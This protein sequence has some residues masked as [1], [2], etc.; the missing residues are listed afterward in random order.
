MKR[1][2]RL[3]DALDAFAAGKPITHA[4]GLSF[5]YDGDV[6][7]ERVWRPLI[8]RF[9]VRRPLVVCGGS[10]ASDDYGP[11]R[12]GTPLGVTVLRTSRPGG[13]IFHPKLFIAVR[14]GAVMV[15]VGS[16]N[17]TSGGLSGNLELLSTLT[18]DPEQPDAAPRGLL[19]SIR[20]FV[21]AHVR[22]SLVDRVSEASLEALDET[23][24]FVELVEQDLPERSRRAPYLSFLHTYD[25]A[26]WPRLLDHHGEDRL[27][28]VVVLSPFYE[29]EDPEA[30]SP[31]GLIAEVLSAQT[32]WAARAPMPRL[33]LHVGS[34]QAA[35]AVGG[36]PH[37]SLAREDGAV[38]LLVQN[39]S[40]E[41]RRLHAKM[42]A[43]FGK[44][45]TTVLWG[46]PNFTPSAF[47]RGAREGE[48]GNV[49]C[50]LVLRVPARDLTP[51]ALVDQ[52]DL[53]PL[54]HVHEGPLP[55]PAAR[56]ARPGPAFEIG[57]ILYDPATGILHFYAERLSAAVDRF[58]LELPESPDPLFVIQAERITRASRPARQLE[59]TDP[60]VGRSR[61]RSAILVV[62]ALDADG[63]EIASVR[64]RINVRFD[65][66]LEVRQNYLLGPSAV[67]AD[68][69]LVPST[70]PPERRVAMID[71]MLGRLRQAQHAGTAMRVTRHQASLD[72][73]HRN[74]RRG[75]EA[76]WRTLDVQRG[77]RW[78]LLRWSVDVRRALAAATTEALDAARRSFLAQRA[79]EHV[80]RVIEAIPGWHA[81]PETVIPMVDP[82]LLATALESIVVDV[83]P[84]VLREQV[85]EV[86]G[87]VASKVRGL[88]R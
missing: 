42:V 45:H 15:A 10:V 19:K 16:A 31:D 85:L 82:L 67:S 75:L 64:V 25:G 8:E 70:A 33:A 68:A 38:Q 86:R 27:E 60:E 9:G 28:R 63:A 55:E 81:D 6:A 54:F 48:R 80:E 53:R 69:L 20:E 37:A 52:F 40:Y 72:A 35:Q 78:A 17:L 41:T 36:L 51:G 76:R 62:R 43:L 23:M 2:V 34:L 71:E 66:A 57:E 29:G 65:D 79:S 30:E 14:D 84:A 87:R 21:G 73:F 39:I 59:E 12:E 74:V 44:K 7:Y 83:E 26:L 18:F 49:E 47:A 13:S 32:P 61:L 5:G 46:S 88:Q 3:F 1:E 56:P 24:R 11:V 77:S 22:A 4:L 58:V 50:A